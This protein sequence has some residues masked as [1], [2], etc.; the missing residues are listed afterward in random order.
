[1]T[2]IGLEIAVI[3]VLTIV[4]GV[5][6]MS[7]VALFS[8]RRS[9]LQRLAEHG[10]ARARR[11]LLL[12]KLK[13]SSKSVRG[14]TEYSTAPKVLK[15]GPGWKCRVYFFCRLP[16]ASFSAVSSASAAFTFTSGS[17]PVPS[18]SVFEKGLIVLTSGIPIP[19]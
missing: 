5:F 1:V 17:T 10:D 19:K 8:A 18:Q 6:A 2:T 15:I 12:Q 4:N 11:A 7:A 9:R 16:S 3:L 13:S 14:A